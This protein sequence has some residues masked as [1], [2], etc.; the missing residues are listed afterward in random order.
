VDQLADTDIPSLAGSLTPLIS[1]IIGLKKHY[2]H[3]P[4]LASQSGLS[5]LDITV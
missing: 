3:P 2:H 5:S 4:Y 1:L